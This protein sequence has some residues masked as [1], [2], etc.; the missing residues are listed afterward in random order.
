MVGPDEPRYA[1][2]AR[3]IA[4]SGDWV[5]PRLFGQPW[6]EKP[7]LYYW[8]AAV[9]FRLN[10]SNEVA[11]RLPSALA[12]LAAVLSV[13]WLGWKF[14][15]AA[16]AGAVTLVLA[17]TIAGM[18]FARAATPDML[19]SA[20][21]VLAM[22]SAANVLRRSGALRDG[23]PAAEAKSGSHLHS[24][25]LFG[26]AL[27]LATLAKGP[28]ALV[29]AGGSVALWAL[30]TRQWRSAFRLAHP[31]AI[32]AFCIVALPW[33]VVCSLRNPE[34]VRTFLLLHNFE[35]YVTP[36]FQ[37]HQ[38]FWFFAPILLLGLLPW[39]ALLVGTA[40]EG[41]RLWRARS[42]H[43]SPGFFFACWAAFPFAFFSFSQSKLPGYIL[44]AIPPLVLLLAVSVARAIEARRSESRWL[45]AAVG[46]TWVAGLA[47]PV[48]RLLKGLPL[49]AREPAAQHIH[50]WLAF[51]A[52]AGLSIALLAFSK[53]P[54]SALI[55]SSLLFAGLAEMANL[56][57]L[58]RMDPYLSART[59]ARSIAAI[60]EIKAKVTS[61]EI[62]RELQ[63]G[64]GFYLEREIQDWNAEDPG[65]A[66]ILTNS[67]GLAAIEHA[68]R[69]FRIPHGAWND[70]LLLIRIESAKAKEDPS[71]ASS[72]GKN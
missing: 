8:A 21:L 15:G 26:A 4:R 69:E 7:I 51:A 65:S 17:T 12:A 20:A 66:W 23:G 58:P 72:E 41:A 52:A 50:L 2:V 43:N 32:A 67:R 48:D 39:S 42:W 63:F 38:R 31:A 24:L 5:T 71:P 9:G 45:L 34:F 60:P 33:Y 37:H 18:A 70:N 57:M 54:W 44:P 68:G 1:E 30:A 14:Y 19:F 11:A 59:T 62:Q 47:V 35:R 53:T 13:A 64:L 49:Y 55:V 40:R 25:I 28:A 10:L 29:L 22:A 6:F 27:G 3:E 36:V 46:L 56:R 61:F 16:T